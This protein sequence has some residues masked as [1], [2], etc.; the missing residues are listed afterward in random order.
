LIRKKKSTWPK[1]VYFGRVEKA[2]KSPANRLPD[3]I[4]KNQWPGGQVQT[5]LWGRNTPFPGEFI[6][7]SQPKPINDDI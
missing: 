4:R 2:P 5:G 6:N 1:T 3:L 7:N